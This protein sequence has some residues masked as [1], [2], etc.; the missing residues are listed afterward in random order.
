MARLLQR[1]KNAI[2]RFRALVTRLSG[3]RDQGRNT[4]NETRSEMRASPGNLR[5]LAVVAA[6][7]Q[8]TSTIALAQQAASS[9]ADTTGQL[10]EVIVTSQKRSE[11]LTKVPQV[12]QCC[13]A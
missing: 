13:R 3:D 11:D 10:E 8:M 4:T 6:L 5:L 9:S 7:G 1:T 12:S 2:S